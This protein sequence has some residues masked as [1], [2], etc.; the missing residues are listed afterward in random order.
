MVVSPVGAEPRIIDAIT[1]AS[2]RSG[3]GFDYLLTT[4]QRESSLNSQAKAK[5]SSASG[6]YQFV[7]QTWLSTLKAHGA[8]HGLGHF[9]DAIERTCEGKCYVADPAREAEI[10]ALRE[11]PTAAAAMAAALASDNAGILKDRL[12]REPTD[13]EVYAAHVLGASGAVKLLA[14]AASDPRAAA[15]LSFPEAAAS[16]RGL[17]YDKAGWPVTAAALRDRLTGEGAEGK[18]T[19]TVMLPKEEG[20]RPFLRP[21]LTV[22]TFTAAPA[23]PPP[24]GVLTETGVHFAGRLRTALS[25]PPLILSP[26]VLAVLSALDPLAGTSPREGKDK[27]TG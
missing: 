13:G 12:G 20:P 27:R 5:T 14:L 3:V 19:A 10:L 8:D 9:A 11:D 15:S 2:T 6:L 1:Q 18:R 26:E 24:A 17:F 25:Q 21:A 16:N 22:D 7:K 23:S 4:A